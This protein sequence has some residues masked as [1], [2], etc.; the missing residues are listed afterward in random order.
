MSMV[1]DDVCHS[2]CSLQ[3]LSQLWR[4]CHWLSLSVH[5]H[6][7]IAQVVGVPRQLFHLREGLTMLTAITWC[8]WSMSL[9]K[10]CFCP[11]QP[12]SHFWMGWT[13][14]SCLL[15]LLMHLR[16]IYTQ[17]VSFVYVPCL[18]ALD[19]A[20][21]QYLMSQGDACRSGTA[22]GFWL[23]GA[24][25]RLVFED[26]IWNVTIVIVV[27]LPEGVGSPSPPTS[28]DRGHLLLQ[29]YP[30]QLHQNSCHCYCNVTVTVL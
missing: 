7:N 2:C 18:V 28:S 22:A 20:K 19:K 3:P 27:I 29:Q 25:S 17:A 12:L 24:S 5:L 8:H 16:K 21:G 15:G 11:P 1:G 26:I 9:C 10:C 14:I 23:I 6:S 13:L 4:W 30:W